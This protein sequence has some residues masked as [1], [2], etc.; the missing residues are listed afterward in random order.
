MP[1]VAAPG[2]E[3]QPFGGV[4]RIVSLVPVRAIAGLRYLAELRRQ[5]A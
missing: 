1:L 5:A 2:R 3:H 4:P